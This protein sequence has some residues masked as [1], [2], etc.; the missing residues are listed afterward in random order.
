MARSCCTGDN[1]EIDRSA[2]LKTLRQY[3]DSELQ[4]LAAKSVALDLADEKLNLFRQTLPDT[5]V[6]GLNLL[7][8]CG[9]TLLIERR[10]HLDRLRSFLRNVASKFLLDLAENKLSF[11]ERKTERQSQSAQLRG[12]LRRLSMAVFG[13]LT[14]IV[15]MLIMVLHPGL[16]TVLLTTSTFVF[17]VG[18]LLAMVMTKA[19]EKDV[20]GATAAYAAVLV[21]FVGTGGDYT[22]DQGGQQVVNGT[23]SEQAPA[24]SSASLSN[25][26]LAGVVVGCLVGS[27]VVMSTVFVVWVMLAYNFPEKIRAPLP[28]S[29]ALRK[30]RIDEKLKAKQNASTAA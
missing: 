10:A 26:Q 12:L 22:S 2:V 5:D 17:V 24:R 15:P 16:T 28:G 30:I 29:D 21:V 4:E 25:G 20:V 27:I 8:N 14:L 7:W 6:D 9:S 18:I 23:F 11:E 19:E 3:G 13:G 1:V